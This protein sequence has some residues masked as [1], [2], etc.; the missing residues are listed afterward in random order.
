MASP[1]TT[2]STTQILREKLSGFVNKPTDDNP[3]V[4]TQEL[5]DAID[6]ASQLKYKFSVVGLG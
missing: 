1:F 3:Y 4:L 5:A 2:S 6:V